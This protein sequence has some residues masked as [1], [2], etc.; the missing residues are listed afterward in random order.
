MKECSE[1]EYKKLIIK[2]VEKLGNEAR[3]LWV[4][5]GG[6]GAF[7]VAGKSG[8]VC[9]KLFERMMYVCLS[10]SSIVENPGFFV[11][12]TDEEFKKVR[13]YL[14]KEEETN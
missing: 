6:S 4:D 1:E 7:T 12:L 8:V 11:A 9:D 10:F 13:S 3:E 5:D 14:M 2:M